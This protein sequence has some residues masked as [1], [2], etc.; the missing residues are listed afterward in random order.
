MDRE[1]EKRRLQTALAD[2]Q[3]LS[4]AFPEGPANELILDLIEEL[5]QDIQAL[6]KKP[7]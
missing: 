1:Q 5:K 6:E 7:P 2:Y 4:R 3:E